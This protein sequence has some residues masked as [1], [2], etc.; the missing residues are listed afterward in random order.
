MAMN[1]RYKPAGGQ[2]TPGNGGAADWTDPSLTP[3]AEQFEAATTWAETPAPTETAAENLP[4]MPP[5]A[6]QSWI[7][8]LAAGTADYLQHVINRKRGRPPVPE[9]AADAARLAT[10]IADCLHRYYSA[11]PYPSQEDFAADHGAELRTPT[12]RTGFGDFLR[13]M[14]AYDYTWENLKKKARTLE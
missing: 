14:E 9:D 4:P 2:P 12:S 6:P 8:R 3:P 13:N 11:G 10:S 1:D 7:G 5:P